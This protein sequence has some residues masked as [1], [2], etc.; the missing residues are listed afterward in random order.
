MPD[1]MDESPATQIVAVNDSTVTKTVK[2]TGTKTNWPVV[3]STI[4]LG[5]ASL[6]TS[7]LYNSKDGLDLQKKR[8][9]VKLEEI[10][11][12]R[13]KILQSQGNIYLA[14]PFSEN[15]N[16]HNVASVQPTRRQNCRT[17]PDIGWERFKELALDREQNYALNDLEGRCL[18]YRTPNGWKG[19]LVQLHRPALIVDGDFDTVYVSETEKCIKKESPD[20]CLS[21]V[22]SHLNRRI[23]FM[24]AGFFIQP[25]SQ[26]Y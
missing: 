11:L 1:I 5:L 2:P 4:L 8:E 15:H 24:G 23:A 25:S 16:V 22:N 17:E 20:N 14:S 12:E 21:F 9:E 18:N 3:I 7:I 10:K 26:H 6:I 13:D 19:L